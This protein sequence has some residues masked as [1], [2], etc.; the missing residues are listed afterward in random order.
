MQGIEGLCASRNW[1]VDALFASTIP[2]IPISTPAG[3][4]SN[5]ADLR[6][7]LISLFIF[8]LEGVIHRI[9]HYTPVFSLL[10]SSLIRSRMT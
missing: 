7:Q 5:E 1:G 8:D 9:A 6:R 3:T 2:F 4:R 10:H